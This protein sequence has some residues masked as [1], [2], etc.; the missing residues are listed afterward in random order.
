MSLIYYITMKMKEQNINQWDFQDVL[1]SII[2]I[3]VIMTL[4]TGFAEFTSFDSHLFLYLTISQIFFY[5]IST[6]TVFYFAIFKKANSLEC[7]LGIKNIKT[8][9]IEGFKIFALILLATTLI[10]HFFEVFAQVKSSEVYTNVD[11]N[12][13][14]SM[15]FI[16]IF[17]APFAEEVF[18]RGFL[19][20]V[21]IQKFGVNFGIILITLA[22]SLLHVLY[23]SNISAFLGIICVGLILSFA[24]EKTGSLIPCIIAH[25][26]NNLVAVAYMNMS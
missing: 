11:K 8:M 10:D 4:Y 7:F 18:F 24:K 1:M 6:I 22:F 15:S 2:F 19:Q 21:F 14:R 9:V 25:F 5:A 12:L 20:P 16:G 13:L 17:F 26:L 23:I 3:M